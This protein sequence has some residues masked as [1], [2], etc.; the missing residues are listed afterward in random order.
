MTGRGLYVSAC[1]RKLVLPVLSDTPVNKVLYEVVP[2][3]S[4]IRQKVSKNETL[5]STC[6]GAVVVLCA[7]PVAELC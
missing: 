1:L 2:F 3:K 5:K 7:I 4:R 6:S